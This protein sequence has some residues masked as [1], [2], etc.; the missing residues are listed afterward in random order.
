MPGIV[1]RGTSDREHLGRAH[2]A[3][4]GG[5]VGLRFDQQ[6][7]PAGLLQV[8]GLRALAR[9]VGADLD[10]ESFDVAEERGDQPHFVIGR[11]TRQE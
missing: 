5:K 10:E 2:S 4:L 11:S 9:I 7:G 3:Q 8:P 6:A 1:G